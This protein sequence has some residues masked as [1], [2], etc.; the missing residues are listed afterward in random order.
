MY[1]VTI[2]MADTDSG[3]DVCGGSGKPVVVVMPFGVLYGALRELKLAIVILLLTLAYLI[4]VWVLACNHELSR[5]P[6]ANRVTN[7]GLSV[8]DEDPIPDL[9]TSPEGASSRYDVPETTT[10]DSSEPRLTIEDLFISVKT[11]KKFHRS[12]LDV[13]LQTWFKL[14]RDQTYFFTDE[15]DEE[16]SS[17]TY[18]HL[19]NTGCPSSHN[20]RAL[21]CKMGAEFDF[22]LQSRKK[23]W[24]HFDDDN[25]VNVP[26][27]LR[28]LQEYDYRKDWYLGK[29]SI[30]DPLETRTRGEHPENVAFWFGT[31]GAGFCIS[32]A[33]ALRMKPIASEGRFTDV[34][35][36]IRLPDDVTMGYIV[37]VLLQ[38]RLTVLPNFHSHLESLGYLDQDSFK[39]QISFSYSSNGNVLSVDASFDQRLD[40]TRFISLHCRLFPQFDVCKRLA[41]QKVLVEKASKRARC[42]K[43]IISGDGGGCS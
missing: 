7:L 43:R 31:G 29:T 6:S 3:N 39:D 20:R 28:H 21:C 9:P 40:P 4:G 24:C 10:T 35:E 11:T 13:I 36:S 32:K 30:K 37:E 22:Y 2:R 14:A 12:R 17:K 19:I 27:L 23:W 33:L 41:R 25:Y 18:N 16:F 38:K 5:T 34:G 26:Q 1:P 15:D 42:L 8:L